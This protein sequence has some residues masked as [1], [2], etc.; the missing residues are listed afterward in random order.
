MCNI[1]SV[2]VQLLNNTDH[3]SYNNQKEAK[4]SLYVNS[5]IPQLIKVREELNRWLTPAYGNNL[6]IDFDFTVIPELQEEMDKVVTQMSSSWWLT[7]NEKRTAMSYGVDEEQ[8]SMDDYYIP[9]N[10]LPLANDMGVEEPKQLHDD[11]SIAL[12]KRLVAGMK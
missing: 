6:Y 10:L 11:V 12:R 4:K 8:S 9:A 3:Q 7:P 2:P 1:Y 5:I